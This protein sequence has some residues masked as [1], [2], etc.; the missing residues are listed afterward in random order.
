MTDRERESYRT[1]SQNNMPDEGTKT[2]V[3]VK[4]RKEKRVFEEDTYT[5]NERYV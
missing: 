2:D 3:I 5:L 4:L 1:F